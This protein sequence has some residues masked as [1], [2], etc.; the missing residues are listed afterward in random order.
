VK[1]SWRKT[2]LASVLVASVAF[3]SVLAGAASAAVTGGNAASGPLEVAAAKLPLPGPTGTGLTRG[4]TSTS[5]TVGCEYTAADYAGYSA[6][7]AARFARTN[8]AGGVYGRKINMLPCKDDGNVVQ[9]NLSDVQQF[10]SQNNVFGLLTLTSNLL[11][12]ST[13]YL[14]SHQVPYFDWGI[15]SGLCGTRWGFGWSGCLTQALLPPSNPFY[16]VVQGNLARAIIAATGKKASQ[17][18]VAFQAQNDPSGVF[19]NQL[20][21]PLWKTVGATVV[22]AQANAPA[23]GTFDFTPYVQAIIAA[24]PNVVIVSTAF[25]LIGGFASALKAAGY[26]GVI[27]DYVT[28]SPGLLQSSPQLTASLQGEYINNQTVPEEE[29]SPFVKLEEADLK[30]DGQAPN[31]T[32]GASI[33]WAEAEEFIE[34]VKATGKNLNTKTFDQTVNGGKF[35]SFTGLPAGGLGEIKWPAAHWL[36]ADCSA[37]VQVSGTAYKVVVPFKC[38]SSVNTK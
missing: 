28:Y 17:I 8:K 31:L 25:S 29:N 5:I 11:T 22:Y 26:K 24:K 4:V 37:I 2:A 3:P 35:T 38:Y 9:T 16:H 19:G 18:R 12:G 14:N 33:G 23:S 21:V 10:V 36:P 20:Y 6:G 32:L 1:V 27:Q 34:M 30:A 13:N 15:L 7:M